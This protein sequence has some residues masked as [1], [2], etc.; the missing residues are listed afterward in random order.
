[1]YSE[2]QNIV[3]ISTILPNLLIG[4]SLI[5]YSRCHIKKMLLKNKKAQETIEHGK[6]VIKKCF[7]HKTLNQLYA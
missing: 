5:G 4:K 6:E 3:R 1:M 7:G 2:Q